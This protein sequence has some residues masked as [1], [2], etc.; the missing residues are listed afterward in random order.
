MGY[1][2]R[3]VEVIIMEDGLCLVTACDSCGAIGD[4][5]LDL[6]KVP[7][8]LVGRLTSRVSLME[9]LCTGA[10]PRIMTVAISSEPDPTGRLILEGI[11]GELKAAGFADLS[12]AISTE[13]NFIPSQTGLGIGL[14]GTCRKH[15]LRI[16][17][18]RPG[19]RVYCLGLPRVGEEVASAHETLI[20]GVDYIRGLMAQPGVHEI[21][22][23][24][25]RGILAEAS[26]LAGHAHTRFEPE[27]D[28]V[29]DLTKS[30]GPSTC[31]IFTSDKP[32]TLPSMGDTPLSLVGRLV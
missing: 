28:P 8:Q 32:M 20:I 25:S 21:L 16:G 9:I 15:E 7:P 23:V 26:Q 17:L 29:P 2:G 1:Q 24:G 6:L 27:S 31:V 22:P 14:T 3:D 30:A 18:S 11:R 10:I 13:K 5:E 19:D 4:K 12:L